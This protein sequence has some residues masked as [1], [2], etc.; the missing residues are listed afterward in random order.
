MFLLEDV[1][2]GTRSRPFL[3]VHVFAAGGSSMYQHRHCNHSSTPREHPVEVER[4]EEGRDVNRGSRFLQIPWQ[5]DAPADG[6]R[7]CA[8]IQSVARQSP[9]ETAFIVE[10]ANDGAVVLRGP[11]L[12]GLVVVPR[13]CVSGIQELPVIGRGHVLAAVRLATLLVRSEN[14]GS[15]SRIEVVR[16]LSAPA[17]H[18]SYQVV[19]ESSDSPTRAS[20]RRSQL[21]PQFARP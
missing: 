5:S 18:V 11:E 17:S 12:A 14:L 4:I 15:T 8:I 21:S 2:A 19:P 13:R 6:C 9:E 1:S 10:S 3:V 16:N 7:S 20:G